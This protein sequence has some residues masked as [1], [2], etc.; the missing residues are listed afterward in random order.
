M[1]FVHMVTLQFT[2]KVCKEIRIPYNCIRLIFWR[3]HIST[4]WVFKKAFKFNLLETKYLIKGFKT[5]LHF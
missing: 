1:P 2:L 4:L 3:V 5:K